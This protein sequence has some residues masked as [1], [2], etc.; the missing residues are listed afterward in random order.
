MEYF[1][2]DY[3][4]SLQQNVRRQGFCLRQHRIPAAA[5]PWAERG[6]CL[7]PQFDSSPKHFPRRRLSFSDTDAAEA[8]L[9]CNTTT[10]DQADQLA[11]L[12]RGLIRLRVANIDEIIPLVIA[13]ICVG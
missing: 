2:L 3:L 10:A 1:C 12:I 4:S 7:L 8:A 9:L 11:G 13:S 6:C 5:G